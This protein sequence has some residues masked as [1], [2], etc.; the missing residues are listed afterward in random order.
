MI[1]LKIIGRG[2]TQRDIASFWGY[3]EGRNSSVAVCDSDVNPDQPQDGICSAE[4][5]LNDVNRSI[6]KWRSWD[7]QRKY[8]TGEEKSRRK[9]SIRYMGFFY[10]AAYAVILVALSVLGKMG[11]SEQQIL[12]VGAYARSWSS[13]APYQ[14]KY[15]L[16]IL[17]LNALSLLYVVLAVQRQA[18]AEQNPAI[19]MMLVLVGLYPIFTFTMFMFAHPQLA[20]L[21]M[22][23]NTDVSDKVVATVLQKRS[24]S[25][26]PPSAQSPQPL[27]DNIKGNKGTE[28]QQRLE[29]R[30]NLARTKSLRKF[31]LRVSSRLSS[32]LS[33]RASTMSSSQAPSTVNKLLRRASTEMRHAYRRFDSIFGYNGSHFFLRAVLVE[34]VEIPLQTVALFNILDE[35]DEAYVLCFIILISLNLLTMPFLIYMRK[36]RS[37]VLCEGVFDITWIILNSTVLVSGTSIVSEMSWVAMLSIA[38]PSICASELTAHLIRAN[39]T[40]SKSKLLRLQGKGTSSGEEKKTSPASWKRRRRLELTTALALSM[41]GVALLFVSFETIIRHRRRCASIYGSEIW[42]RV[43]PK[44]IL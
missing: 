20:S 38:V 39:I 16:V 1:L 6:A 41:C 9:R 3:T 24:K 29:G 33:E 7:A 26:A 27:G 23:Y 18:P 22:C 28:K 11:R 10:S 40:P 42:R 19:L 15:G 37:L 25:W 32:R 21:K 36:R 14:A 35:I 8:R 13:T 4:A 34:C 17:C 43:S 5:V 12:D 44:N 30:Q 2:C 31:A